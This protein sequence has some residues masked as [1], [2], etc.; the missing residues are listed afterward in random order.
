M[1]LTHLLEAP[2]IGRVDNKQD[3]V[4][5]GKVPE[6]EGEEGGEEEGEERRLDP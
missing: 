3:T 1:M 6:E 4:R 5:L 2:R